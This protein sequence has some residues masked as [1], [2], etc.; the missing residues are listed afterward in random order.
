MNFS[1]NSASAIA[2]A[3]FGLFSF[4]SAS[5]SEPGQCI[6]GKGEFTFRG[7]V[8]AHFDLNVC[9]EDPKSNIAAGVVKSG[10]FNEEGTPFTT[11]STA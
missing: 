5:N 4:A 2:T 1:I 3:L 9:Q 11:T 6:S 10:Q 8:E 7:A